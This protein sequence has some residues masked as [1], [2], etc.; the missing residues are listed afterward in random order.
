MKQTPKMKK[1]QENLSPGAYSAEGF[2]GEDTRNLE[3]IL[4]ED[5][6][7]VKSMGLSHEQIAAGMKRYTDKGKEN[8][9][10]PV[11][12][13]DCEIIVDDHRG[14][15]PCPF[16]DNEKALKTNTRVFNKR[17]NRSVYWSDLN[18]HMIEKHGFYEGRGSRFRTG[19]EELVEI[20]ELTE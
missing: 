8:P 12:E 2:L 7:T 13:V 17:L 3:D 11:R 18:I 5:E 19:P 6:N 20:L 4:K 10:N 16:S 14:Y 9:G 15:I 1:I